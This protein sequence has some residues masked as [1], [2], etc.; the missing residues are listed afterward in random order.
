MIELDD[1]YD[2][3][4][5]LVVFTSVDQA[6]TFFWRK[7]F[8]KA[9]VK[10]LLQSCSGKV[11]ITHGVVASKYCTELRF[12]EVPIS[13]RFDPQFSAVLTHMVQA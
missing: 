12:E 10:L 11:S 3:W 5:S 7:L 2:H 4:F 8:L 6:S 13:K 1:I 9:L